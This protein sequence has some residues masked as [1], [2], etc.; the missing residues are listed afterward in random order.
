MILADG[1]YAYG[2]YGDYESVGTPFGAARFSWVKKKKSRLDRLES[3][4]SMRYFFK[5]FFTRFDVFKRRLLT[6]LAILR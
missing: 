3:V 5:N 1:E 6:S 4:A 2:E